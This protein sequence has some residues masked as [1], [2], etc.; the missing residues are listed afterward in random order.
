MTRGRLRIYLGAAPG[1][2]KTVAML[3]EG[4]RRQSRGTD[5]V[6]GYCE[7]HGRAHTESMLEGLE[8]I[9]RHLVTHRGVD[10]AEMDLD[11]LLVRHP[12][13]ALVDELAHTNVPG[14]RN[15]KRWQDI[16]ELLNAGI[17]V[18]STVNVQHLESLNDAVEDITGVVQRETVPDAVV[19]R[20]DQIELVDMSPEAL[21]RR[22]AHGNIYRPEKVDAA[23]SNYFR[24]GN[25]S[26]LR[27]LALLWLADRVDEALSRYR[28]MHGIDSVWPTR[29]R[30]VVAVTGGPESETLLRRGARIASRG[31]GDE[32]MAVYVARGDGLIGA[33][34]ERLAVLRRLT[35]EMGGVFHV[36][37]GDDPG[38]AVLEYAR[39]AN[40]TQVIIGRSRKRLWSTWGRRG[41]GDAVIAGSGEIDIHVVPHAE[42][43]VIAHRP[44]A[45]G[46][47]RE[48]VWWGMA[49][50]LVLPS[51][52]TMVLSWAGGGPGLPLIVQLYLL[53]T[54][55]VAL[56]GGMWPSLAT[57]LFSSLLIN[58]Y[59]TPPTGN[60]TMDDPEN[61][62]A[63]V[64]FAVVAA[65]VAMVV[66][67]NASRAKDALAARSE[68]EALT[69]LS[70]TLLAATDQLGLLLERAIELLGVDAAAVV[71]RGAS[72]QPDQILSATQNYGRGQP[73]CAREEID[74]TDDLVICGHPLPAEQQRLLGAI[75]AHAGA[76]VS[77]MAL[78]TSAASARELA[79]DNRARTALL[80]AVSHDLRTPLAGIKAAIGSLRSTDVHFDESDQQELMAAVEDSTDR[81]GALIDDLLDMSRIQAGALVAHLRSVDLAEV[82]QVCLS[83]LSDAS[84]VDWEMD[85]DARWVL[86]D[87][88]LLDRVLG[89]LVEN[90]IKHQ[91]EQGKIRL[92]ASRLGPVVEIRVAD[93]GPGVP[94]S[95]RD[96]IFLPFQ[97][98]GDAPTGEGVGL[99][100]AVARGLAEAMNGQVE[101]DD[102]PGG[103]L[104]MVVGLPAAGF[105][106]EGR[107]HG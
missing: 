17:D 13:V 28:S 50:A 38:R 60:F 64:L 96:R 44:K 54:I 7:T 37:T 70:Q 45:S 84:R 53:A 63:V 56:I 23:L 107:D 67:L 82:F 33:P 16:E 3:N 79:R 73:E 99:G 15:E 66:H 43:A 61:A 29:E 102:T 95:E 12:K 20:A 4:K 41:V 9:P 94:Q 105:E 103:G 46:L 106:D 48:R 47:P 11:A 21:R 6:V 62:A 97:R 19:R 77:R 88:G 5:V 101:A 51:I 81:L 74:E 90:A 14:S 55:V 91:P 36:V 39:G 40:A 68:S 83:S 31:A 57:A 24:E 80:S 89:N 72:G 59:F 10:F 98:Y 30:V 100:L 26:A 93:S 27:E 69:E 75:V 85:D 87:P 86:A 58:W 8:V 34:A 78:E 25:L 76:V 35:E 1:V 2:G 42:S 92:A 71:R 65:A 49:A 22:M 18:I 32:L 104:T 52:L